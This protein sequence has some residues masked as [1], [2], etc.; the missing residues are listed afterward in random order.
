MISRQSMY[1]TFGGKRPLYL[2]CLQRYNAD[3][4]GEQAQ[5]LGAAASPGTGLAALLELA[6]ENAIADPNPR[7]LGVGAV[8]EFGRS[9]RE[10]GRCR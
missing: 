1:D 3:S 4:I 9:D 7:C 2:E 6:V 10:V 5:T 8:T